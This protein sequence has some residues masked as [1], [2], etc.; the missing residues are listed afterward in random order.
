M[1]L[2][3][4]PDWEAIERDRNLLWGEAMCRWG[5]T[6]N[7]NSHFDRSIEDNERFQEDKAEFDTRDPWERHIEEYWGTREHLDTP[8]FSATELLE[9]MH[10][11]ASRQTQANVLRL[12][13]LLAG[14][15]FCKI[16]SRAGGERTRKWTK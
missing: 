15:G 12:T 16:R 3:K 10:V 14:Q 6:D 13:R 8:G 7:Y 11:P 5:T 4:K 1:Q 2:D 9:Y